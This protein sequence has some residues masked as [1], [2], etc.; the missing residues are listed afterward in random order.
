MRRRP[1][2]ILATA[3][4]SLPGLGAISAQALSSR[5]AV[6][7][8]PSDVTRFDCQVVG[9][10]ERGCGSVRVGSEAILWASI[11]RASEVKEAQFCAYDSPSGRRPLSC[12]L[13]RSGAPSVGIWLNNTAGE[14]NVTMRAKSTS[15]PAGGR[16][17]GEYWTQS[18]PAPL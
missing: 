17:T 4:L 13:V 12:K 6:R 14:I 16:L 11:G 7:T 3:V 10:E 2:L 5:D 9:H 1:L 8:G 18:E 15:A